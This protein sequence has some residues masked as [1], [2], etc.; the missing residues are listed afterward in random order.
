[1][2]WTQNNLCGLASKLVRYLKYKSLAFDISSATI[3]ICFLTKSIDVQ[4]I[5]DNILI[6]RVK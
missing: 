3:C 1:M 2:V 5:N 4:L 6:L